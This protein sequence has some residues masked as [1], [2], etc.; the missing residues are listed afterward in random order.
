MSQPLSLPPPHPYLS[1]TEGQALSETGVP[2]ARAPTRHSG[3]GR[4]H[5]VPLGDTNT[6]HS[7]GRLQL[8]VSARTALPVFKYSGFSLE[9]RE[10][11]FH[12]TV[13]DFTAQD[14]VFRVQY[15][16]ENKDTL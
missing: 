9:K 14:Y 8:R 5:T 12:Y 10:N 15:E 1:H 6:L 2:G 13:L 7:E 3:E 11:S 4:D 16:K